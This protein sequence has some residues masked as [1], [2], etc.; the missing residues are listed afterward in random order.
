[1]T[2]DAR[3]MVAPLTTLLTQVLQNIILLAGAAIMCFTV[4]WKLA[5]LSLTV[6]GPIVVVMDTF[7]RFSKQLN[8]RIWDSLASAND[9]ANQAFT[10]IRTVKAFST[11]LAEQEKYDSS[12][13]EMIGRAI[14]NAVANSVTYIISEGLELGTMTLILGFGGMMAIN[15]PDQLSVGDL[16]T[17]QLYANMMSTAYF[18]LNNVLNQ[19]TQSAGAAERILQMLDT[20]ATIDAGE[21]K[22]LAKDFAGDV[23]FEGVVFKYQMRP[24]QIVLKGLSLHCPANQ[25]TAIVGP[26]GSGKSTL[27]HLL[28][29]F[30][31]PVEGCIRVDGVDLR[32]YALRSVHGRMAVVAQDTQ[33]FDTTIL[34]N[35]LYGLPDERKA[36]L[37]VQFGAGAADVSASTTLAAGHAVNVSEANADDDGEDAHSS[38][39]EDAPLVQP[40]PSHERGSA[41][42]ADTA[43]DE[44]AKRAERLA[45][46]R[47]A[48]DA[49]VRAN[50]AGFIDELEEG[51]YTKV[52]ERGLRLSGGQKQ[53]IAIARAFLRRP[54]LLLLDEATSALDAQSEAQVQ[55]ALDALVAD[56]HSHRCTVLIV[57]HRL[58]TVMNAD[59]IAV[60]EGGLVREEGR[61][62]ELME[63]E[64][65][66]YRAFVAQT[67]QSSSK[68]ED[69]AHSERPQQASERK[70]AE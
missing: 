15:H 3:A 35:I 54:R 11:E 49:A 1:M 50:A 9:S 37:L 61:H 40:V 39:G 18:A 13:Y 32:D 66:L 27:L 14:V 2:N 36:E 23:H 52:G 22:S 55:A 33:L 68:S 29:R 48:S 30:Y 45:L 34:D 53:R 43:E 57:A 5:L 24:K 6:V 38:R 64:A 8:R 60:V 56:R 63:S 67:R 19:F 25:V 41:K 59:K 62:A 31:D 42:A 26:S 65:G 51:Y 17:F 46:F 7:A 69:A 12:L 10:N 28:L 58:S 16:V 4:S 47:A 70:R 44:T 21:G 20:P